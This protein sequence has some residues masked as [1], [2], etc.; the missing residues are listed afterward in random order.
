MR[1]PLLASVCFPLLFA[2]VLVLADDQSAPVFRIQRLD[3]A[4]DAVLPPDAVVEKVAEGFHWAEGPV[5]QGGAVLFSDVPENIIYRW[6]PGATAAKI[7]LQPSG[8][9]VATPAFREPGSNGLARDA[10]GRLILCQ[11]G[12][13]RIARLEKDGSQ[14]ALADRYEGKRFNSPN[15]LTIAKNGDIFFTDPPYGL[16]KGEKSPLRELTFSGV[17]RLTGG[18]VTLLTDE[19]RFPNGIALSPDEKTLYL[20]TSDPRSPCVHAY[21]LQPDG[22]LAKHRIFFDATPVMRNGPGLPD[23][24]K[25]DRAGN[26][27]TSGPGGILIL[28][29]AGRHLGTIL[30]GEPTANCGWGEDGGTLFITA[31]KFLLRVKT[32]TKG[33]GW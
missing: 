4:L 11:H 28:S 17:Y 26:V 16:A 25:V 19:H 21:D 24:L 14:T 31:N 23:G 9:A 18:K 1:R 7:F 10:E 32:E 27:W 13:R 29:P 20:N 8:G 5:W 33:A 30:T 12:L 3:P 6:V 15:D 22:T 2:P